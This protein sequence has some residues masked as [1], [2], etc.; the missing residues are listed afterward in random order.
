M[1]KKIPHLFFIVGIIYSLSILLVGCLD[2]SSQ[3][4]EPFIEKV[5]E[6]GDSVNT[7]IYNPALIITNA[8]LVNR[9]EDGDFLKGVAYVSNSQWAY[10]SDA[11]KKTLVELIKPLGVEWI[12]VI[13]VCY[14]AKTNSINIDCPQDKYRPHDVDIERIIDFAHQIGLKV[15]LTPHIHLNDPSGSW[16]GEIGFGN[17]EADWSQWFEN[18]TSFIIHYADMAEKHQVDYFVIGSEYEM[19]SHREAEWR[20]VV[21]AVRN[22]YSGP[23]TYSA[24]YG[25]EAEQTVQWWDALDAIAIDAYY[26]LTTKNDPTVEELVEA[27]Q[28]I[29]I[30]L[31]NLSRKWGRPIIFTEI[32]YQSKDGSNTRPWDSELSRSIDHQE[33]A[34]AYAA[35]FEAFADKSWWNGVF[36]WAWDNNPVQGGMSNDD[37]EIHGKRQKTFSGHTMAENWN[38]HHS[39][40]SN[41]W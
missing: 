7:T 18:Y 22:I 29:T 26:P 8:G 41:F 37:Y 36:W 20:K 21:A 38:Q 25:E 13:P 15:M 10:S 2:L 40:R 6:E 39:Q 28:P 5:T 35:V 12:S 23:V 27:W 4:T 17:N 33:Q 1:M 34:D 31:E 30:R 9:L 24:N 11:S 14:Q 3:S 16:R 32:G 19:T